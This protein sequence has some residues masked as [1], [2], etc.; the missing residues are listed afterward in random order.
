MFITYDHDLAL[1]HY[2]AHMRVVSGASYEKAFQD[3]SPTGYTCA[4]WLVD[5][6][7][8]P[9]G[10]QHPRYETHSMNP[11][12][13]Q[14]IHSYIQSYGRHLKQHGA[15]A[16]HVHVAA[17]EH[18]PKDADRDADRPAADPAVGV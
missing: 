2:N 18:A 14:A 13:R 1:E 4:K 10:L 6:V 17:P 8:M 9:A 15:P 3:V 16:G 12:G 11:A 5:E 7:L